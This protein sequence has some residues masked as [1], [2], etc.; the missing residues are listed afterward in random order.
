VDCGRSEEYNVRTPNEDQLPKGGGHY[1]LQRCHRTGVP[2]LSVAM[3]PFS[4]WIHGHVPLNMGAG[5]I[6]FQVWAINILQGGTEVAKLHFDHSKLRKQ[7]FWEK[8]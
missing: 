6:F 7:I 5:S 4:I 2:K 1:A 3:Y 8:G